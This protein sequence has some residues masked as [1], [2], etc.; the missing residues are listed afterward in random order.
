VEKKSSGFDHLIRRQTREQRAEKLSITPQAA[1]RTGQNRDRKG[2][3]I[4]R[5][6]EINRETLGRFLRA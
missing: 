4:A 1:S 3:N 6:L 2:R 5:E